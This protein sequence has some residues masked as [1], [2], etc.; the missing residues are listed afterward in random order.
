MLQEKQ[1]IAEG[2]VTLVAMLAYL[3]IMKDGKGC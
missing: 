2:N 1:F 3:N